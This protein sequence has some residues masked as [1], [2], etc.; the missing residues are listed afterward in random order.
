[1]RGLQ[2]G[3]RSLVTGAAERVML[4]YAEA[5]TRDPAGMSEA[6]GVSRLREAGWSDRAILDITLVVSYFNFV[7]RMADGLGVQ[8]EPG[9]AERYGNGIPDPA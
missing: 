3:D 2:R 6:S 8:L 7:N 4:D 5:L 1:V 9:Y